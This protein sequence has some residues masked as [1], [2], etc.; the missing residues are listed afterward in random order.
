MIE[1]HIDGT[2]VLG[3]LI[4]IGNGK[5]YGGSFEVFPDAKLDDSRLDICVL[6]QANFPTLLRIAPRLLFQRRVP[7]A[8]VKRFTAGT[9]ELK[10]D[11]PAGLE[12]DGEWAGSLPA[13]ISLLPCKLRLAVP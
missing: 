1:V 4:L 2:A 13:R 8:M 6:K 9:F 3:E 7:A 10:S 5:L 12:L 11:C